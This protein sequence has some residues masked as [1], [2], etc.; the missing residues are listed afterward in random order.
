MK[1]RIA[2]VTGANSGLGLETSLKLAKL[3]Y[4]VI[5]ACRNIEKAEEAKIKLLQ[6]EP[7]ADLGILPL[8][9]SSLE[10]VRKFVSDYKSLYKNVDLLINN[11]GVMY[12]PYIKTED[13]FE[14]QIAVN[15]LG[16]FLL[17][18]LL[19]DIMPDSS[20][21]RVVSL[22]SL[23]HKMGKINFYNF[24][25]KINYDP[26]QAYNQSKLA[27]L[28]FANELQR[29]IEQK[30]KKIL[31]VAAHPGVSETNLMKNTTKLQLF[32]MQMIGQ[33]TKQAGLPILYAA[34]KD[35]INGGDYF[36]PRGLFETKGK[37]GKAK[38][39]KLSRNSD[40]ASR[41]WKKSEI[42]VGQKFFLGE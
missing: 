42:L 30:G 9:L 10:S 32:M 41:L 38:M 5:M 14:T 1:N 3:E 8:D 13:G 27:C 36:G 21:S 23:A 24:N 40:V 35:E 33:P 37:V 15:Y 31:S 4:K 39:S 20:E 18:A 22:S 26:Q 16:H 7:T 29:R 19:I 25:S 28:L 6:Q 17:T 11:A 2:V 12:T 34:T